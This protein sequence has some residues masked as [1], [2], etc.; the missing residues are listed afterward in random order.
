M[1]TTPLTAYRSKNHSENGKWPLTFKKSEGITDKKIQVGCGQC[2]ECRMEKARIWA[3]RCCN[4][5]Q[6]YEEEGKASVFL[7]LTYNEDNLPYVKSLTKDNV[8]YQTLY[9]RDLQLFNK[10]LRK[11]TKEEYR[12][13]AS[14]EYGGN[15]GRPHYHMLLFGYS[16]SRS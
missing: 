13:F 7:T 16:P 6:Y 11:N 8:Y 10:R 14:G 5:S 1:C 12:Y 2:I 4:E 3:V 15:Y 9:K